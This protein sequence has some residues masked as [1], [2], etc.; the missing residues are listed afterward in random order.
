MTRTG[1]VNVVG[2]IAFCENESGIFVGGML[3]ADAAF[4]GAKAVGLDAEIRCGWRAVVRCRREV[5]AA[6][7][8]VRRCY[9]SGRLTGRIRKAA[10]VDV[11]DS[12]EGDGSLGTAVGDFARCAV[13]AGQCSVGP[14]LQRDDRPEFG[15]NLQP[16]KPDTPTGAAGT[17]GRADRMPLSAVVVEHECR[18]H[19]RSVFGGCGCNAAGDDMPNARTTPRLTASPRRRPF[20]W[21]WRGRSRRGTRR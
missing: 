7:Q 16:S 14:R 13:L 12:A 18:L 19:G 21:W 17:E 15:G 3:V 8:C 20:R 9:D 5:V 4:A 11:S 2:P 10:E 1:A 6:V